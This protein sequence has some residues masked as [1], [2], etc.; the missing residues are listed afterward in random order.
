MVVLLG[1]ILASSAFAA[2]NE[3]DTRIT[4]LR[5]PLECILKA[6]ASHTNTVLD[7]EIP[8]PTLYLES[9]I[10]VKQFQDA[11]EPQW[12]FR[13]DVVTNAY[14]TERNEIYM[15]DLLWVY[16]KRGRILDDSLAHELTHYIQVKYKNMDLRDNDAAEMDA[17]AAQTWFRETYKDTG[18]NPCED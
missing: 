13:P 16:E 14:I 17:I 4:E 11:V 3:T 10:P 12:S 1:L 7:P 2:K 8:L 6:V 5:F 9:K 18:R 15:T